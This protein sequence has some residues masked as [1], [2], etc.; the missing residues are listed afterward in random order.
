[1]EWLILALSLVTA[2]NTSSDCWIDSP[3][4]GGTYKRCATVNMTVQGWSKGYSAVMIETYAVNPRNREM[5]L[6]HVVIDPLWLYHEFT[7]HRP[8]KFDRHGRWE[9]HCKT[10]VW[11]GEWKT[12]GWSYNKVFVK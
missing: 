2:H 12:I 9:I 3:E 6:A 8:F 4:W 7:L 1:M 5:H 10:K 11:D